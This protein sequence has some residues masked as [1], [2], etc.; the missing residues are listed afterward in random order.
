MK[1][2]KRNWGETRGNEL[3]HWG[4]SVWYF[5]VLDD[6]SVVR[7]VEVY[8][9]GPAL[10]Y[11]EINIED[12]YGCLADQPLD[13][14]DFAAFEIGE[15]EFEAAWNS[16]DNPTKK[17]RPTAGALH[18]RTYPKNL[19]VTAVVVVMMIM[20]TAIAAFYITART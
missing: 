20:A 9:N 2:F 14:D 8:T 10:K 17:P 7:Q 11:D 12:E 19:L 1:Y 5:E 15:D 6:G 18:T 4:T 16:A 13:L 3:E